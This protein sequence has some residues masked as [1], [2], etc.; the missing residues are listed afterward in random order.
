MLWTEVYITLALIHFPV[1]IQLSPGGFTPAHI[2]RYVRVN[3]LSIHKC[4]DGSY[5]WILNKLW[6]SNILNYLH[7]SHKS[8]CSTWPWNVFEEFL[9]PAKLSFASSGMLYLSPPPATQLQ[10][11]RS[12]H[13]IRP[14]LGR[15][16]DCAEAAAGIL[17]QPLVVCNFMVGLLILSKEA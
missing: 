8:I 9:N 2:I 5:H 16:K 14:H 13:H 3:F 15:L 12:P 7:I 4:M 10:W 11:S 1:R 6:S 17:H